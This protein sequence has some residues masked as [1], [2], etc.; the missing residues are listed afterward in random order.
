MKLL[1]KLVYLLIFSLSIRSYAQTKDKNWLLV[2]GIDYKR[3]HPT[4]KYLLDSI[5]TVY[6][7][8]T[9][10]SIRLRLLN[11]FVENCSDDDLWPKFNDYMLTLAKNGD[12]FILYTKQML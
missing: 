6:H 11:Y 1:L 7:K 12:G 2:D 5:L 10:D 3:I 8:A 4:N 9:H